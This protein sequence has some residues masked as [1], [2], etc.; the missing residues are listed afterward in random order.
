[1]TRREVQVVV[2]EECNQQRVDIYLTNVLHEIVSRS[3]AQRLIED[4]H[5][6]LG[7]KNVLKSYRVCKGDVFHV[8]L[9]I[10][11]PSVAVPENI[12]INIIYEDTDLIVVSKPRGMVVHPAAGNYSGTLVNALLHHTKLSE[13]GGVIR[14]GIVHR[15][16]KDTGGLMVVA[17]NN[18]AHVKL[19]AQLHERKMGRVYHGL[20]HGRIKQDTIKIDLPIG[21]HPIYRKKMAV[22]QGNGAKSAVTYVKVL[23][24]FDG[25]GKLT[26]FEAKLETGRTHQIRV[27]L[28][29]MGHPLYGDMVYGRGP[30]SAGGQLLFAVQLKFVH[31]ASG[32]KMEFEI[33]YP[34][35]F[36]ELVGRLRSQV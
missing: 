35:D 29:N 5:V 19:A 23:E 15:L 26:L 18:G 34:D 12:P 25:A 7:Q 28:A 3:G 14:P 24:R 1:M 21:R 11:E 6:K 9:P 22:K 20:S 13:M 31:P 30:E 32:E 2:P 36:D 10:P 17:K 8:T 33:G 16:D 4:G 27:H